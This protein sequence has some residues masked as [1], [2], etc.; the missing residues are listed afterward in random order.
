M[1]SEACDKL[2]NNLK[3]F[4]TNK[5]YKCNHAFVDHDYQL[6]KHKK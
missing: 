5:I 4:A 6:R 3:N 1:S 2:N